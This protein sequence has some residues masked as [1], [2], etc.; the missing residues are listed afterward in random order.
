MPYVR[1]RE[2]SFPV[3]QVIQEVRERVDEGCKEVV[4]TGTRIGSYHHDGVDLKR[5]VERILAETGIARLRLSSLQPGEVTPGMLSLWADP[6]LCRH[7]HLS[8]Q[9]G[10]AETIGRMRRGYSLEEYRGTLALIRESVPGVAITTDVIVGFPG[11]TAEEFEEG[12]RFCQ[13]MT[14]ANIHVF[15]YSPRSGTEAAEMPGQGTE[16]VKRERTDRMLR[17]AREGAGHFRARFLGQRASVLWE[18]GE[19]GLCSGLTDNYIRVLAPGGVSAVNEVRPVR[20]VGQ[21]E[22]C[23]RGEF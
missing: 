22:G 12:Y 23:L 5:L 15:P 20:I 14:F 16:P 19:G 21:G 18:R 11:E 6:R 7:F 4:L 3:D 8:L 13:G 1:G 2:R 17:L 10:S 9:S